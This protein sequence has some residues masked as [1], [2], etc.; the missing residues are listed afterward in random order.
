MSIMLT[1]V[2]DTLRA[3]NVPEPTARS[4]ATALGEVVSDMRLLTW[5]VATNVAFT[6]A[7]L[8]AVGG[9]YALL[10]NIAARLPR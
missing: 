5:M 7:L 9:L 10:F 4:G 3:A 1:A 6:V 2:Y 8:G